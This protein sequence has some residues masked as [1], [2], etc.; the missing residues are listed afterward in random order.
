MFPLH[1]HDPFGCVEISAMNI[2]FRIIVSIFVICGVFSCEEYQE[3]CMDAS[4]T[5]F[6]VSNQLPCCCEYPKLIF[7]TTLTDDSTTVSF[8]DTFTNSLGQQYLIRDLRFIASAIAVVDS[9]D[10][11]YYP[12]D[13]FDHYIISPDILAI[14]VLNL[15][16][17]GGNFMKDGRF[18]ELS[19]ELD[20]ISELQGKVPDDFPVEH[21]FRDSFFFDF[22]RQDWVVARA[23]IDVVDQDQVTI[24]LTGEEWPIP[25]RIPGQ[26]SKSRGKDLTVNFRINISTLF[27]NMDFSLPE[28]DLKR[29]FGANLPASYEP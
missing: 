9:L 8:A 29:E 2:A 25:I 16:S 6:R 21:P 14:D 12:T 28:S 27:G 11:V 19:F 3:G 13:T 26:W 17:T 23:T 15:N 20:Q 5:N 18:D 7:Q 1:F 24:R 10:K 4:A 22:N